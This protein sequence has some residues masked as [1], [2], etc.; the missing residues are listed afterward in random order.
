MWHIIG[1]RADLFRQALQI[2]G[3]GRPHIIYLVPSRVYSSTW[4]VRAT[5]TCFVALN[6][7][8]AIFPVVVAVAV[9]K[10]A[11]GAVETCKNAP[12]PCCWAFRYFGNIVANTSTAG[13]PL[14]YFFQLLKTSVV[15]TWYVIRTRYL[16]PMSWEHE[17]MTRLS[18]KQHINSSTAAA[19][20]Q[21]YGGGGVLLLMFLS[22]VACC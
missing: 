12:A 16:L 18:G 17:T 5:S 7:L 14:F 3:Q 22:P 19:A 8:A 1:F 15:H 10:N 6:I 2:S 9:E 4:S 13:G 20:A 11:F 21:P